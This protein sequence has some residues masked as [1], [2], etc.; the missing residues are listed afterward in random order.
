M[1]TLQS[2]ECIKG[3]LRTPI[4]L[5]KIALEGDYLE[6]DC[7]NEIFPQLSGNPLLYPYEIIQYCEKS[8]INSEKLRNFATSLEQYIYIST[9][10]WNTNNNNLEHSDFW[11]QYHLDFWKQLLANAK[12]TLLD[13]GADNPEESS[14]AYP[15]EVKYIGLDPILS[16]N[17]RAFRI[18][19]LAEF[20]PFANETLDNAAFGTSLDHILDWYQAL[21]EAK[22]I[23]K[24]HGN[25]YIATLVWSRDAALFNDNVH[26]HHFRESQLLSAL[27]D[28]GFEVERHFKQPWKNQQHRE[29]LYISARRIA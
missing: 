27:A 19:G 17:Y 2:Y 20:L 25:L 4:T 24:M 13:I 21:T 14:K 23:L 18:Y 22:R 6:S 11:Y 10:K 15:A 26:F 7:K 3:I 8:G 1:A 5:K 12:G 29:C 16:S 28:L 9:V